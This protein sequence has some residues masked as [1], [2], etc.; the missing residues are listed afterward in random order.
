MPKTWIEQLK[1]EQVKQWA[2]DQLVKGTVLWAGDRKEY[3]C[4]VAEVPLDDVDRKRFDLPHGDTIIMYNV[5]KLK[6]IDEPGARYPI[7]EI[8]FDLE[9]CD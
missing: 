5:D 8:V 6:A 1:S 4:V 3:G 9:C 2:Y 7:K